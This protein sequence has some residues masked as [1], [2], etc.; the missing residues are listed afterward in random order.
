MNKYLI[1]IDLMLY[2]M[3]FKFYTILFKHT[4]YTKEQ[5]QQIGF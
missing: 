4:S 1:I 3:N 2:K 5:G